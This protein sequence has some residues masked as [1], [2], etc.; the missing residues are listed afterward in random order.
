MM[1]VKY[2]GPNIGVTGL[3]DGNVYE[4]SEIVPSENGVLRVVDE[5]L[6]NWNWKE[7]PNWLPGYLYSALE[8][9]DPTKEYEGA[10]FYIVEDED[11]KLAEL[12]LTAEP[13]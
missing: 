1:R 3:F 9:Q 7:D 10:K 5:D 8:P 12:G 11:G 4:V 2:V 6:D 13:A